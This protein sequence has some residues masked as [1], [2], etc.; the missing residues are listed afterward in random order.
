M[1]LC[2]FLGAKVRQ[3]ES[4]TSVILRILIIFLF[5]LYPFAFAGVFLLTIRKTKYVICFQFITFSQKEDVFVK[6]YLYFLPN[7]STFA[8]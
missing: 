7:R 5:L 3:F 8:A 4:K 6:Y 2:H 1:T